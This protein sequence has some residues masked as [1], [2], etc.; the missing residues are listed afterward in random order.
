MIESAKQIR[1]ILLL[2]PA[3]RWLD[4]LIS[5]KKEMVPVVFI[6]GAPRSGTTLIYQYLTSIGSM[7]YLTNLA[8]VFCWCPAF[9]STLFG[10]RSAQQGLF[11]S[12]YG[13]SRGLTSPSEASEIMR[14]W[15][16]RQESSQVR[17]AI[18]RISKKDTRA[19]I[20]KNVWNVNH[21][22]AISRLPGPKFIVVVKRDIFATARSILRDHEQAEFILN[23]FSISNRDVQSKADLA[24]GLEGVAS[25]YDRLELAIRRHGFNSMVMQ[26][27]EFCAQPKRFIDE[28][29][30]HIGL[31]SNMVRL[32]KE[33]KFEFK[34]MTIEERNTL[35]LGLPNAILQL[36]EPYEYSL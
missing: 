11:I 10:F 13:V 21:L 12:E 3:L 5:V 4:K 35:K 26:Y 25:Y 32:P 33:Q 24:S 7:A 29:L 19:F 27:E 22:D 6:L 1:R 28:Y 9:I 17:T 8:S 15:F 14:I 20:L 36:A 34:S 31:A 18:Q 16:E 2:I 23:K 30:S